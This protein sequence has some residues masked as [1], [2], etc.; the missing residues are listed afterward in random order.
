M[1]P[2]AEKP[3]THLE[4]PLREDK[5]MRPMLVLFAAVG[6]CAI[7]SSLVASVPLSMQGPGSAQFDLEAWSM[8]WWG[9]LHMLGYGI[10]TLGGSHLLRRGVRMGLLFLFLPVAIGIWYFPLLFYLLYSPAGTA[11]TVLLCIQGLTTA[12]AAIFGCRH[13]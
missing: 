8:E 1:A 9:L 6:G 4:S 13:P 5:T 10:C 11:V 12:L 7:A 2:P 3:G